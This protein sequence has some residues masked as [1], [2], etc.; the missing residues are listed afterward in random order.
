VTQFKLIR[1]CAT[2]PF[3]KGQGAKFAMPRP[4]LR[5]IFSAVAFQCHK[6]VDYTKFE[7]DMARQGKH[8]QQCA[9]LMSILSRAGN[10]NTIMQV[11]YRMGHFD[12]SKL[13]HS[14][15]YKTAGTAMAAHD[16]GRRCPRK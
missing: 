9:G 1:P 15:V 3:R 6:T 16:R 4:R 13:D 7:D 11:G 5:A 14:E 12:S 8:P 2:C 10:E